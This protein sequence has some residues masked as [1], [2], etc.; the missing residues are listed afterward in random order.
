MK[1]IVIASLMLVSVSSSAQELKFGDLNYLYQKGQFNVGADTNFTSNEFTLSGT[2]KKTEGF[3]LNTRLTY[4]LSEKLNAFVGL[5]YQWLDV[6]VKGD[7]GY[8]QHGLRNPLAG[9]LFRMM[10][11][12]DSSVNFDLGLLGRL[13]VEDAKSGDI[14]S[15]NPK[16]GNA[17]NGRNSVD[18]YAR[19]GSKW[20]IANEWQL[21]AG[22]T[23]NTSGDYDQLHGGS[24]STSVDVDSSTDYFLRAFY[25]WRPVNEFMM[26][27]G[28][29]A[30]EVSDVETK[31]A[32]VKSTLEKHLDVDFTFVAKFLVTDNFLVRFNYLQGLHQ[33]YDVSSAGSSSKLSGRHYQLI[34]LG[35]DYLF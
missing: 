10:G 25:Q 29:A 17:S 13:R 33:Q 21:V 20:N 7:S 22:V 35:A 9:V 18:L 15:H 3:E 32:G 4:G 2:K 28:A 31:S 34:G 24:S 27:F 5:E 6:D 1:K 8:G 19:L 12:E 11:Q 23:H 26:N 30:T 16:D 14:T